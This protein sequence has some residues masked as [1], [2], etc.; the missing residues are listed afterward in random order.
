MKKGLLHSEEIFLLKKKN[1]MKK[2]EK[3]V[4]NLMYFK[5]APD[6]SQFD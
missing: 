3:E 1:K 6:S 5:E 2:K 4:M